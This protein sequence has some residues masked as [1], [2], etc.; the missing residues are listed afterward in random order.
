MV[1][2]AVYGT[3][4]KGFHN[5]YL[6]ENSKFITKAKSVDKLPMIQGWGFPY[7]FEAL[8][9]GHNIKVEIYEVDNQTLKDLDCLE[10]VSS[11]HY[12][13]RE[14]SFLDKNNK[15]FKAFMYFSCDKQAYLN[16][17]LISEW[18]GA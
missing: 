13:R 12:Y 4:K 2:I 15:T 3:L 10:G 11:G 8:G 16:K 1:K 14:I 6:L 7:A 17:E 5:H 9:V 18:L